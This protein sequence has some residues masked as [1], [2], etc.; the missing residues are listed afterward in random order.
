M[1]EKEKQG[2]EENKKEGA[3]SIERLEDGR[4]LE[5]ITSPND[6]EKVIIQIIRSPEGEI[7]EFWDWEKLIS[8]AKEYIGHSEKGFR[9]EFLMRGGKMQGIA[10]I[11]EEDQEIVQYSK[12]TPTLSENEKEKFIVESVIERLEKV[13]PFKKG[14]KH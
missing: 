3:H 1:N 12:F 7:M 9:N 10:L 4:I 6:P 2:G 11:R 13:Y 8:L 5:I 14:M